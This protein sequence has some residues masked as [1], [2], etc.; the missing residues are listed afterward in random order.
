MKVTDNT[1]SASAPDKPYTMQV[2]LILERYDG[3]YTV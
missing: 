1:Y 3:R 2:R